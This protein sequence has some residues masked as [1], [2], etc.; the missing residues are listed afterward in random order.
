MI[1]LR[2]S[3]VGHRMSPFSE[4]LILLKTQSAQRNGMFELPDAMWCVVKSPLINWLAGAATDQKVCDQ[5]P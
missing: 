5:A 1:V 3:I 2:A 4:K